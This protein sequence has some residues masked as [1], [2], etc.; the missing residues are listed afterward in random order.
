MQAMAEQRGSTMDTKRDPLIGN[1]FIVRDEDGTP[2]VAGRIRN[3]TVDGEY[4]VTIY[5]QGGPRGELAST[6]RMEA[7]QWELH[8]NETNW[9]RAYASNQ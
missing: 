6:A 5:G 4:N 1:F 8:I 3:R 2:I 7:E 9:R